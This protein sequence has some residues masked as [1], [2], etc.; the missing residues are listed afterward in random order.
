MSPPFP[1]QSNA[2]FSRTASIAALQGIPSS[3]QVVIQE[4]TR[5]LPQRAG[6]KPIGGVL[7]SLSQWRTDAVVPRSHNPPIRAVIGVG[8]GQFQPP[9]LVVDWDRQLYVV[10]TSIAVA[11]TIDAATEAPVALGVEIHAVPSMSTSTALHTGALAVTP[12]AYPA[13]AAANVAKPFAATSVRLL[14]TKPV[15]DVG[16][17][18]VNVLREGL[19]ASIADAWLD[20][21]IAHPIPPGVDSVNLQSV[22]PLLG[23][24]RLEFG[25]FVL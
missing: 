5:D 24:V 25:G 19:T 16:K 2:T 23:T 22:A 18:I 17:V 6:T 8:Q 21:G 7:I 1:Q 20:Q 3:P 11:W 13:F 10:A 12:G 9:P 14:Y 15:S 4:W